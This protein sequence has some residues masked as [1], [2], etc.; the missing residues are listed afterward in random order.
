MDT[1][2]EMTRHGAGL[3]RTAVAMLASSDGADDVVQEAWLRALRSGWSGRGYGGWLRGVVRNTA[4]GER[5]AK[6]REGDALADWYRS[7]DADASHDPTFD[8]AA[9]AEAAAGLAHAVHA[10]PEHYREV[11]VRRYWGDE[12][13]ATIAAALGVPRKTVSNRL[14]RALQSLRANPRTSDGR[15]LLLAGL[16]F[17]ALTG[18]PSRLLLDCASRFLAMK[19]STVSIVSVAVVLGALLGWLRL[20][21][22]AVSVPTGE[23]TAA[24]GPA[25]AAVPDNRAALG[26]R[27]DLA[28]VVASVGARAEAPPPA[29]P[30]EVAAGT[31][32]SDTGTVRFRIVDAVTGADLQAVQLRGATD[33]R[34][35]AST[36]DSPV[37]LTLTPGEWSFAVECPPFEGQHLAAFIV[38]AGGHT[39][40]PRVPLERGWGTISGTIDVPAAVASAGL[41]RVELHGRGRSPCSGDCQLVEDAACPICGFHPETSRF[42]VPAG[43]PFS[44]DRLA[45]GVYRAI[46]FDGKQRV[47]FNERVELD[48]GG[49]QRLDLHLDFLDI[50]FRVT[51]ASGQPFEGTWMEDGTLYEG[52]I[53]FYFRSEGVA[54]AS[55]RTPAAGSL[56]LRVQADGSREFIERKDRTLLRDPRAI[57]AEKLFRHAVGRQVTA[58]QAAID[59]TFP[60]QLIEEMLRSLERARSGEGLDPEAVSVPPAR[61]QDEPRQPDHDIAFPP[62]VPDPEITTEPLSARRIGPGRYLVKAVPV[63]TDGVFVA[64]GPFYVSVELDLARSA[65]APVD[66]Q[67]DARCAVPSDAFVGSKS[68]FECHESRGIA[69]LRW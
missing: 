13:I 45:G 35:L 12:D 38:T 50:P 40:L 59:V 43:E 1:I 63:Q 22:A 24:D 39:E 16:P 53:E 6:R 19:A 28:G 9:T 60:P 11:V 66:L 5:R 62:S 49:S 31:P 69:Q 56:E 15:R 58:H 57:H 8:A 44:F 30:S 48:P 10:L 32:A 61:P 14:H 7:R 21:P 29:T 20:H 37:E 34:F 68:C 46:V 36:V 25:S 2:D 33:E 4:R 17:P 41:F 27:L 67:F 47:L 52:P 65:G 26:A 51:D 54:C 55:A 18:S 42:T 64:C 23:G 3:R